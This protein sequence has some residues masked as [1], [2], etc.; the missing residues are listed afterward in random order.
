MYLVGCS[1]LSFSLLK[2]SMWVASGRGQ[3]SL[4]T[5][6]ATEGCFLLEE[7]DLAYGVEVE[8][9]TPYRVE[10]EVLGFLD[11]GSE[12]GAIGGSLHFVRGGAEAMGRVDFYR[13]L[14]L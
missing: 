10:A 11:A 1:F 14:F 2:V 6:V 9:P 3:G 13:I 7:G 12:S 8:T 5:C 4:D